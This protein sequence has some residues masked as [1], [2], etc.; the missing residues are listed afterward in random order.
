MPHKC[1]G[2]PREPCPLNKCD[3]TVT[4][5]IGDLWL[6]PHCNDIRH[7]LPRNTSKD[8][9]YDEITHV[10]QLHSKSNTTP[11]SSNRKS[12]EKTAESNGKLIIEPLLSY[13]LFSLQNGTVDNVCNA[14]LGHFSNEAITDAKNSLWANSDNT[15]IGEKPRRKDSVVRSEKKAHTMDIL[16]ALGKLDTADKLPTIAIDA[17]SLGIIPRSHPEELNN[18]SLVDRLNR[19]EAKVTALQVIVDGTVSEN[20]LLK[21]KLEHKTS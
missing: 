11:K 3:S 18:I 9:D 2:L 14:I 19:L 13:A 8:D 15:V 1:E 4:F 6:C 12:N 21:E 7:G 17:L 10:K 16:T 20:L 5:S